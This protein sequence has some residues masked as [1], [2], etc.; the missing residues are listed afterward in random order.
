MISV[1]I[2]ACLS[3]FLL[4]F[5]QPLVIESIAL[6]K[7]IIPLFLQPIFAWLGLTGL[8]FTCSRV[9]SLLQGYL[10][11][12]VAGVVYFSL[13]LHW[14]YIAMHVYG[15]IAPVVACLLVVLLALVISQYW[16]FAL[17]LTA[18][19]KQHKHSLFWAFPLCFT[20][21]E[22][23]RHLGELGF[24][25]GQI[26]YALAPVYVLAQPA[27]FLGIHGLNTILLLESLC[28][29]LVLQALLNANQ[30]PLL[31]M[32]IH[33][34]FVVLLAHALFGNIYL[35]QVRK[36]EQQADY[37]SI[38]L[39]QG[40]IDQKT[41]NH[42]EM[43][44]SF[45]WSRYLSLEKKARAQG[46]QILVWPEGAWPVAANHDGNILTP[47][48]KDEEPYAYRFIRLVGS[49]SLSY[50]EQTPTAYYNS[51]FWTDENY[52]IWGVYDKTHLVPFG[53][54]VPYQSILPVEKF[55]SGLF[56]TT[57]GTQHAP[58][59]TPFGRIG[60]LICYEGIFPEIAAGFA[61]QRAE[62]LVNVTNDAW[63]GVSSAPYQ[64]LM[65]YVIRAIETGLP[66][67]RAAN[68]GFSALIYPSGEISTLTTLF[69]EEVALFHVPKMTHVHPY[70]RLPQD[71]FA[72]FN[73]ILLGLLCLA[74]RFKVWTT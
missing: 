21:F 32:R 65:F 3:G 37:V 51:L 2:R 16:A 30:R 17:L 48:S 7:P 58:F 68:T 59:Q 5:S 61:K 1:L 49:G 35:K 15:G 52:R 4:V 73:L 9:H 46:A 26:G 54:Y 71:I 60:A 38:A 33:L 29:Y 36:Q 64:H 40:N 6:Q 24:P 66:I 11:G 12:L 43:N 41:K 74:I 55:V 42:S 25:W 23:V 28:F 31:R 47:I 22:F 72:W 50:K 13:S 69:K 53:E 56:N 67:A 57:V 8:W 34:L 70:A 45:I 27:A 19:I 39:L 62:F 14:L 63:Y 44:A 18:W 10:A 20:S